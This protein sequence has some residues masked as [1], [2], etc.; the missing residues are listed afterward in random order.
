VGRRLSEGLG[1]AAR[2]GT[3]LARR[4]T[5]RSAASGPTCCGVSGAGVLGGGSEAHGLEPGF[6][7]SGAAWDV[8]RAPA[9]PP[10]GRALE[11]PRSGLTWLLGL[12]AAGRP[13]RLARVRRAAKKRC[14]S[15][16]WP[17]RGPCTRGPWPRAG[18]ASTRGPCWRRLTFELRRPR[19]RAALPV[20]P[21]MTKGGG[22]G[23][24]GCR[25]GSP[26]ERGVR[27]HRC[28][29]H[30]LY[31]RQYFSGASEAAQTT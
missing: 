30:W 6:K 9:K 4:S 31:S 26:L 15:Q 10:S 19:R 20:R 12:S 7:R 2:L 14:R 16:T 13:R 3:P 21:M 28:R 18:G 8:A 25:S 27:R 24:A 22:A 23:K 5:R 29:P 11:A 17:K 1:G